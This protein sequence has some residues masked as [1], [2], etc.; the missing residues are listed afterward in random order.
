MKH[1]ALYLRAPLQSWGASS[2]F[3]DRGTLD[4]PTRSGLLGLLAAACG[5]DKNDEERDREWLSRATKLS[6]IALVFQRGDR[7]TDYHTVGARYDKDDPWQRRMIPTTADGKPRGTDLT[8]RDY[9]TDSV[10][11]AILSG[12][13]TLVDEM[14]AGLTDPVWG[15]WLGRK[16]CIPTEPILAGVFDSEDNAREALA[17]RLRASLERSGGKVA[18]DDS[19][20]VKI[21][22]LEASVGEEEEIL[23]DVPVSF[24]KREFNARRIRREINETEKEK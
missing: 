6:M 20:D 4:A 19:T 8:H 3:G 2:K 11:G 5:V 23:L 21:S 17:M 24:G 1:L 7:M 16:S 14:A 22:V 9:L 15:V 13:D 12:D 10:F 18:D